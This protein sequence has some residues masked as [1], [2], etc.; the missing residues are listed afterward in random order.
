MEQ[1]KIEC[2]K[3]VLTMQ[4]I[5]KHHQIKDYYIIGWS[6]IDLNFP[7]IDNSK[8]YPKTCA[9]LFGYTGQFNFLESPRNQYAV[10]DSKHPSELGH[11]LIAKKLYDWISNEK[12]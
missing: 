8:I 3:N 5:C 11:K 7:G 4:Q 10:D 2:F 9:Q 12:T 1:D 6:D